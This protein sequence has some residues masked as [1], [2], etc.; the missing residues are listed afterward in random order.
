MRRLDRLIIQ[1]RAGMVA[2]GHQPGAF[3]KLAR[4]SYGENEVA[5]AHCKRCNQMVQVLAHPRANEIEI[6]GQAVALNCVGNTLGMDVTVRYKAGVFGM[7][8][9]TEVYHNVTEVH[10]GYP[11][12][13]GLRI[14]FESG[15]HGTGA[16]Y[17]MLDIAEMKVV[18]AIERASEF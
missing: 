11:S 10:F 18:P 5:I 7:G 1:A 6:G 12:S 16:A 3:T 8:E 15:I 2:R 13:L 17:N 9:A 4:S 14:A